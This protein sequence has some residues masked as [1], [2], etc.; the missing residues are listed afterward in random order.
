[1]QLDNS[2]EIHLDAFGQADTDYYL[3]KARRLRAEVYARWY[4]AAKTRLARLLCQPLF[5]C[6][7]PVASH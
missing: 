6:Q 4:R 2:C 1:M 5:G 7:G 3:A